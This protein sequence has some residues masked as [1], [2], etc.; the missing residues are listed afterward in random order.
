MNGMNPKTGKISADTLEYIGQS[1]RDILSTPTGSR[2]MR[3]EY[4]SALFDLLDAPLN[5]MTIA[6]IYA[7]TASAVRQW[8]PM[9]RVKRVEINAVTV[10][11]IQL[12]L[13]GTMTSSNGAEVF[14]LPVMVAR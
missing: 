4:G 8:C 13:H 11:G 14:E 9:V 12:T 7:A 10:A 5:R 6:A 3:R 2:V 1:I